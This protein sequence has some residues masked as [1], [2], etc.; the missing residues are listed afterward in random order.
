MCQIQKDGDGS[1][2]LSNEQLVLDT[3]DYFTYYMNDLQTRDSD[4]E[5]TIYGSDSDSSDEGF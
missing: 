4:T 5:P 3:F 2:D 1:E